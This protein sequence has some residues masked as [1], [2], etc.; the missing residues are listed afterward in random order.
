MSMRQSDARAAPPTVSLGGGAGPGIRRPRQGDARTAPPTVSRGGGAGPGIMSCRRRGRRWG[1]ADD[2]PPSHLLPRR[3][4]GKWPAICHGRHSQERR[5][6]G[7]TR[8][9]LGAR[10]ARAADGASPLIARRFAAPR[11]IDN[12]PPYRRFPPRARSTRAAAKAASEVPSRPRPRRVSRTRRTRPRTA[13][14]RDA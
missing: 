10:Q 1:A 14:G 8:R 4:P 6:G 5:R 7:A 13:A 9:P 2:P 12:L 3:R 11:Q